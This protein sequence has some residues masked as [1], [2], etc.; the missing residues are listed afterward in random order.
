MSWY[1]FFTTCSSAFERS[2]VGPLACPLHQALLPAHLCPGSHHRFCLSPWTNDNYRLQSRDIPGHWKGWITNH[3]LATS[4]NKSRLL[5]L[6]QVKLL[7]ACTPPLPSPSTAPAW[8]RWLCVVFYYFSVTRCFCGWLLPKKVGVN[9]E[10]QIDWMRR[11]TMQRWVVFESPKYQH[12][13][14]TL[15]HLKRCDLEEL[16]EMQHNG[17]MQCR[18]MPLKRAVFIRHYW[19]F[20]VAFKNSTKTTSNSFK[21]SNVIKMFWDVLGALAN[22]FRKS[23]PRSKDLRRIRNILK[24]YGSVFSLM[25]LFRCRSLLI[26][27]DTPEIHTASHSSPV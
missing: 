17:K 2:D 18:A 13:A 26:H 8:L 3:N 25:F 22:R 16:W 6:Q 14:P 27:V 23:D 9:F 20:L 24:L 11:V 5:L 15:L 4:S 19:T 7:Y 1:V 21:F 10:L 12:L